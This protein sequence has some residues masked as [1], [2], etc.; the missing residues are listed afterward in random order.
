MEFWNDDMGLKTDAKVGTEIRLRQGS[1]TIKA[2]VQTDGSLVHASD[3]S[4]LYTA[5]DPV[6]NGWKAVDAFGV[7]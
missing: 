1:G 5:G 6:G 4:P 7:W 3:F 2:V